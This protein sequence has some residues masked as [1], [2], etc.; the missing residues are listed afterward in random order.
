MTETVLINIVCPE[1]ST[2]FE[3]EAEQLGEEGRYVACSQCDHQWFQPAPALPES[4]PL[5]LEENENSLN[6]TFPDTP[7]LDQLEMEE[8]IFQEK[9]SFFTSQLFLIPVMLCLLFTG[10]FFGRNEVVRYVPAMAKFYGAL[11]ISA[12]NISA[13]R[14]HGTQWQLINDGAHRSIEITGH[15]TNTSDKLLT[16]P[17]IQVTLKGRGVCQAPSW[18]DQLLGYEQTE[19]KTCTIA[20]WMTYLK[21]GRLFSGQTCSFKATYALTATQFPTEVLL[22]FVNKNQ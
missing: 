8:D 15:V 1:C 4:G 22:K 10:L 12:Y 6:S 16:P 7:P 19:N 14:F 18:V 9:A 21:E 3:I 20:K 2:S 17:C 13:F 11:G 5:L